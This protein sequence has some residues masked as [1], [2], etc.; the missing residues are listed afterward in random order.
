M[1]LNYAKLLKITMATMP[2]CALLG[3]L[4]GA[5]VHPLLCQRA[6]DGSEPTLCLKK[7]ELFTSEG[8]IHLVINIVKEGETTKQ[9]KQD[10]ANKKDTTKTKE[11]TQKH[12]TQN[13]T[14]NNNQTNHQ[15]QRNTAT[16][17]TNKTRKQNIRPHH[18]SY[19]ALG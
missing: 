13:K 18:R 10:K 1:S 19:S 7:G 3:R 2:D 9:N 11:T 14:K 8:G 16:T 6:C 15:N 17:K 4:S 12:T 5:C